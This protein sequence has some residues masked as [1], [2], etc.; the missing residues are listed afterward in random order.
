MNLKEAVILVVFLLFVL[1]LLLK[2]VFYSFN[3]SDMSLDESTE[4]AT[5]LIAEAS[6]PWWLGIINFLSNWGWIGALLIIG[7]FGFLKY[8]G[9]IG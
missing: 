6:V 4:T 7:L 9:E 2:V 8:S 3:V 1:P 5:S